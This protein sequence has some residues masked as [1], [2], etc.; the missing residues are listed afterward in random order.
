MVIGLD[1]VLS[2]DIRPHK[3]LQHSSPPEPEACISK[4]SKGKDSRMSMLKIECQSI[5]NSGSTIDGIRELSSMTLDSDMSLKE[6]IQQPA[7]VSLDQ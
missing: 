3:Q 7:G 6:R 2:I 1:C 5:I 4:Q